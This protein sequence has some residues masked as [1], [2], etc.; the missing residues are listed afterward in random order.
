LLAI[1]PGSRKI[2]FA[3]VLV[4]NREATLQSSGVIY[5]KGDN[6][7]ER[8][9]SIHKQISKIF[10][11]HKPDTL[12]IERP[13]FKLNVNTLIRLSEARG[14]ILQLAGKYKTTIHDYTPSVI[15]KS[16]AGRG[17]ASKEQVALMAGAILNVKRDWKEDEAD[18]IAT[19]LCHLSN[20]F[21]GL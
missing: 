12:A 10:A 11:E 4:R 3:F 9:F 2:G 13:F 1:D 20:Y 19:A 16:V 14:V 17:N 5:V 21:N 7:G 15:K 8:L 18:A 6:L